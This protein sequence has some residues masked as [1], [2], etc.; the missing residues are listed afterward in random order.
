MRD[1]LLPLSGGV[2]FCGAAGGV[3]LSL[4]FSSVFSLMV[5]TST[6]SAF[7]A[8]SD[9]ASGL[10]GFSTSFSAWSRDKVLPS[11]SNLPFTKAGSSTS[12]RICATWDKVWLLPLILSPLAVKL[13]GMVSVSPLNWILL[14]TSFWAMLSAG[15]PLCSS[16]A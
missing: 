16:G 7:A 2:S 8:G 3:S 12:V 9:A 4:L 11:I 6:G 10:G 14:P 13:N 1:L 5:G 15:L